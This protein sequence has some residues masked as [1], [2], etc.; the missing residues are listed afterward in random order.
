MDVQDPVA[1]RPHELGTRDPHVTREHDEVDRSLAQDLDERVVE[2]GSILGARRIDVHRLDR[3]GPRTLER[4]R[5]TSITDCEDH[6]PADDRIVQ[7]R[8]QVG[9]RSR[10]EDGHPSGHIAHAREA[11]RTRQ[12]R[13]V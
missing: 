11:G 12:P 2:R 7:Q 3:P 4:L 8:L 9:P 13:R 1:E 6:P 5:I 10:G